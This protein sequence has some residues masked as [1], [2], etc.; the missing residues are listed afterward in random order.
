MK[1]ITEVIALFP[2]TNSKQWR[3]HE[4]GKGWV[5]ETAFADLTAF[6]EGVVSGNAR[7]YGNAWG[8][9]P[10]YIQGTR[11]SMTLCSFTEI[12]IG[13]H[14][15][16]IALWKKEYRKIG[17]KEDYSE[18]EIKE[19]SEYIALLATAAKR[20]QKAAMKASQ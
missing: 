17:A 9:S 10:L 11:H 3:Q 19:Y 13:C 20:F 14:I 16:T 4:N 6:I 15:H 2:Y 18:A 7:V 1:T 12:A 8:S 5:F